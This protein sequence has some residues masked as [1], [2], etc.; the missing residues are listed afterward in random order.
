[1]TAEK[2]QYNVHQVYQLHIS[3][4]T[5]QKNYLKDKHLNKL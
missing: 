3:I 4:N 1:M 5:K 2:Y